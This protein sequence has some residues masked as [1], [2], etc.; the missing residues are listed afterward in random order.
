[1][2]IDLAYASNTIVFPKSLDLFSYLQCWIYLYPNTSNNKLSI[3]KAYI[4]GLSVSLGISIF[5]MISSFALCI[6]SNDSRE[7]QSMSLNMFI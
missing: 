4:L 2:I 1:M 7:C 5:V 3:F 6:N